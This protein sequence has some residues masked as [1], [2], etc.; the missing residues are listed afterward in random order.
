M[1]NDVYT[2]GIEAVLNTKGVDVNI[3][4]PHGLTPLSLLL[5]THN[6]YPTDDVSESFIALAE[7]GAN[8]ESSLIFSGEKISSGQIAHLAAMHG[9]PKIMDYLKSKGLD[10]ANIT[11]EEGIGADKL[12]KEMMHYVP[13]Q[14]TV[15]KI[16]YTKSLHDDISQHMLAHDS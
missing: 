5:C 11:N 9:D 10:L 2:E 13:D 14:V 15:N 6:N 3:S 1:S 12:H 7:K 4:G 8:L 16:P